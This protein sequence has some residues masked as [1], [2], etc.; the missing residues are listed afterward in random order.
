MLCANNRHEIKWANE[1]LSKITEFLE[2]AS[3]VPIIDQT[4]ATK[5]YSIDIKWEELGGQDTE[6]K[7]LQQVLLNQLG[8]ELVPT[9][10]PI[11]MLVV[12]KV[13]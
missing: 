1:P 10:M 13:K 7:V 11:E 5:R 4:G 8:L 9:N 12:E 6:H 2:S 3:P